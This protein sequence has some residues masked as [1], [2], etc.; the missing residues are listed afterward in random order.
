MKEKKVSPE[1]YN[2]FIKGLDLLEIKLVYSE[3][4]VE[5][6]F[7]LPAEVKTEDSKDYKITKRDK[8]IVTQEYKLKA[9]EEG[10]KEAG[11]Y[12]NAIYNV[13]YQFKTPITKEI[14][15]V[16]SDI[17]LPLHTWPYFR[18]FVHETTIRMGLLP[19]TPGLLKIE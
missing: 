3:A 7:S 12:I 18:Q 17:S 15:D 9:I 10:K 8:F 1:S 14:F 19:L 5:E 4:K 13:I 16:F 6:D 11:F 2:E